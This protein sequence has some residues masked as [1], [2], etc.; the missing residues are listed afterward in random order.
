MTRFLSGSPASRQRGVALLVALMFLIVLT[1]LGLAA[2]RT[3]TLEERMA[4]G[5]RDYNTA[6]QAAEAA[7]RDAENDLK[8]TGITVGRIIST[9]SFPG[10]YIGV[11]NGFGCN[12]VGATSPNAGL[13]VID[14]EYR[15][16]YNNTTW[17]DWNGTST[18]VYGT[19]T[20]AAAINGVARP[21]R[22]V[23]EWMQFVDTKNKGPNNGAS[24]TYYVRVTA[25]AWGANAQ[26]QVTVQE[27]FLVPMS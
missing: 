10:A 3:T 25:R 23:L 7:L 21:P 17:I 24:D 15:Q 9:G 26:T 16:L 20:G 27:I 8:G 14:T 11:G 18:V 19:W 2:M 22:Y 6:L 12:T 13:C 1:L 5:S 4:G